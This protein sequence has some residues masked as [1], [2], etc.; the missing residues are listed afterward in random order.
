ML[1]PSTSLHPA[2]FAGQVINSAKH[3]AYGRVLP[4]I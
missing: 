1:S 3:L 2:Q 4:S